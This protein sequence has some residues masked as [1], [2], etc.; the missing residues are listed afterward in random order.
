MPQDLVDR[1]RQET[2]THHRA[3]EHAGIMPALLRG[4]IDASHYA[5]LLHDLLAVYDSLELAL[6]AHARHAVVGH[7]VF[8]ALFRHDALVA[9][10]ATLDHPPGA[11]SPVTP[12][13]Q[14]LV[15]RIRHLARDDPARLVAHAY[16][17][18]LGDLSGGQVLQRVV[19]GSTALGP[20]VGTRFYDF[21]SLE[22]ARAHA[23]RFRAG[24]AAIT[25]DAAL[26][27]ALVAEAQWSFTQ[28]ER[29]FEALAALPG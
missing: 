19:A 18:Y 28:H 14:A 17:R 12:A 15:E 5:R 29:L 27:D 25:A 16:V 10:L 4:E 1:L 24:L 13:A 26:V 2:R 11:G 23:Q 20:G 6:R 22:Q 8:P 3:A 21:G 9:D 7:V